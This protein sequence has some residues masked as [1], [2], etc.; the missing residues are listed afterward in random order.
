MEVGI[1]VLRNDAETCWN[2][3]RDGNFALGKEMKSK[4]S[5]W[6]KVLNTR[7]FNILD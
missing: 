6:A 4:Y 2:A 7:K 3:L 1:V 5:L